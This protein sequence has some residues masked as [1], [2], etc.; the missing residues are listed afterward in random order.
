[1]SQVKYNDVISFAIK[2]LQFIDENS[3]PT[4]SLPAFASDETLLALYRHMSLTR[5][6]DIKAINLQRTGH[7]GGYASCRGQEAVSVG[8]G[9]AMRPDDVLAPH[10]RD[11]GAQLMRGNSFREILAIW[12]G[13]EK[14]NHYQEPKL[15]QDL[16]L[17]IPISTQ[18]LHAAGI[19]Y[20]IKYRKQQRGVITV[21]GDGGTSKGDFYEAINIA[22]DWQLPVV[23]VVNNNQWAIS[24]PRNKQTGAKTLAQKAIAG[25]FDSLQVDGNDVVAVSYAVNEALEKARHGGGPTLIEA[26]TY[27]LCDHTTADD[28]KRYQPSEDVK[29]AWKNEPIARLGF[30]LEAKGVWSKDKETALQKELHE[31][32]DREMNE[33]VNRAKPEI[34][35]MFDYLYAELPHALKEQRETLV[36]EETNA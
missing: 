31:I 35:D 11:Q 1:M 12:G 16:P 9:H 10:Y 14:D 18:C 27:R 17:I 32:V 8:I 13:D 19:A 21:C 25:G 7:L 5:V 20:A 29:A 3:K 6:F 4:Q 22:G 33:Y 30:Y 15:K 34:T 24:V 26:I 2:H 28:A 23:F 36:Q